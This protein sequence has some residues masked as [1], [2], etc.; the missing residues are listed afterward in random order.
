MK[1]E[2]GVAAFVIDCYGPVAVV[3]SSMPPLLGVHLVPPSPDAPAPEFVKEALS[4]EVVC[5]A[6]LLVLAVPQ[7]VALASV[8]N[9]VLQVGCVLVSLCP[10]PTPTPPTHCDIHICLSSPLLQH[11]LRFNGGNAARLAIGLVTK[12]ACAML[13]DF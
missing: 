3:G 8:D 10:T 13:S 12:L 2:F 4:V 11:A 9:D 7:A 5:E 6:L 1:I